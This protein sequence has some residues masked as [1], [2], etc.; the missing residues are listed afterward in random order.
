MRCDLGG[1]DEFVE[2]LVIKLD[3]DR[4]AAFTKTKGCRAMRID[5]VLGE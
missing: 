1:I 5:F 4:E 2:N 3:C